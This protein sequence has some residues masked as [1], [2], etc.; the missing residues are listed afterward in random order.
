MPFAC[1]ANAGYDFL[2]SCPMTGWEAEMPKFLRVF[3]PFFVAVLLILSVSPVSG[4]KADEEALKRHV[5]AL[6]KPN[7]T[8]KDWL[9]RAGAA[10]RIG[11]LGFPEYAKFIAPLLKDTHPLV[12]LSAI[13]GLGMC[14]NEEYIEPLVDYLLALGESNKDRL[15]AV[16]CGWALGKLN[17]AKAVETLMAKYAEKKTA[18]Y[19]VAVALG[20][21]GGPAAA[22]ALKKFL[23]SHDTKVLA[24]A[25]RSAGVLGTELEVKGLVKLMK[26]KKL[27]RELKMEL[28]NT[29]RL[30]KQEEAKPVLMKLLESRDHMI[31]MAAAWALAEIGLTAKEVKK[32]ASTAVSGKASLKMAVLK[33]FVMGGAKEAPEAVIPFLKINNEHIRMGACNVFIHYPT[34]K[35]KVALR[36]VFMSDRSRFVRYFAAVALGMLKDENIAVEMANTAKSSQD[37]NVVAKALESVAVS[38]VSSVTQTLVDIVRESD[39]EEKV[40]L[41]GMALAA[42]NPKDG[43]N[44]LLALLNDADHEVR[45]RAAKALRFFKTS[46]VV[47]ALIG[48]F[49][50]TFKKLRPEKMEEY[51]RAVLSSLERITGHKY[52][53]ESAVWMEWWEF[54]KKVEKKRD[55]SKLHKIMTRNEQRRKRDEMVKQFGGSGESEKGVEMGLWWLALHQDLDGRWSAKD[56]NKHDE[57]GRKS[58]DPAAYE[59]DVAMAGLSLLCYSSAGYTQD[60]GK[61]MDVYERGLEFLVNFMLPSGAW[62]EH[63][64]GE[65]GLGTVYEEA[66]ALIALCEAYGMTG[67]EWLK[68]PAQLA[69]DWVQAYQNILKGWRYVIMAEDNDSSVTGWYLLAMK[70]ARVNGLRVF[71]KCFEGALRWY[72]SVSQPISEYEIPDLVEHPEYGQR[73]KQNIYQK[74]G[75]G[76]QSKDAPVASMTAIGIISRRFVGYKRTHPLLRAEANYLMD[77]KV[78]F[79]QPT[80]A[81][82]LNFSHYFLYYATLANFQMGAH[83]WEKWNKQLIPVVRGAQEKDITK[84][85]YGSWPVKSSIGGIH[86]GRI[87]CTALMILTLEIYYRYIPML[88]ENVIVLE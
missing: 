28:I 77:F 68:K 76:Y 83:Y 31:A 48:Q 41:A 26:K 44:A 45:C 88:E 24:A 79:E 10:E 37:L 2:G 30:R 47:T 80:G 58:A 7:L 86:G 60:Y 33:C 34:D 82:N 1:R 20:Y 36:K 42:V 54:Y 15:M 16:N 35:A 74:R 14:G 6:N 84:N 72:D 8:S 70:T 51:K 50:R 85:T 71:E 56:F 43:A 67:A 27:D 40:L 29:F 53:P 25:I 59:Y 49:D 66:T 39:K 52:K 81:R 23:S 78:S 46:N 12:R 19:A 87:Y 75:V 65:S 38:G 64:V 32:L 11:I 57:Q 61:Y 69:T 17:Q 63:G 22:E 9:K 62:R 18:K 5:F 4:E 13:R 3:I 73:F 21:I 55:I